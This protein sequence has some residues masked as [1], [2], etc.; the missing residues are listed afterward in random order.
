MSSPEKSL[1]RPA[2]NNPAPAR[3]KRVSIESLPIVGPIV[4]A[5]LEPPPRPR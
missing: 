1:P 5:G 4:E 2:I 3:Q